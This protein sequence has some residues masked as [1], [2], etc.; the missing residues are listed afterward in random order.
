MKQYI[1]P[2]QEEITLE[3]VLG[4]LSDPVRLAIVQELA[5]SGNGLPCGHFCVEVHKSTLSH[6]MRVLR[7]A[8]IVSHRSEGTQSLT[9]LRREELESKFPGLL[10]TI[11]QVASQASR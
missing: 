4:A 3:G 1:H 2:A 10:T 5:A 9:S 11:L 7:E 8:G 6:H